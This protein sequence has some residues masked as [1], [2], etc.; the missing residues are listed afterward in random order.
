[1]TP[2]TS[3]AHLS[4]AL[5]LIAIV[6]QAYDAAPLINQGPD[7]YELTPENFEKHLSQVHTPFLCV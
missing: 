6:A 5:A 7:V 3:V 1:M 2:S 4:A